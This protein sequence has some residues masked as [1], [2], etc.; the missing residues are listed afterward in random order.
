MVAM[1]GLLSAADFVFSAGGGVYV[2]GLFT[3]YTLTADGSIEGEPVSVKADQK[4]NQFNFGG[5]LFVDGTWAEFNLGMQCGLHNYKEIMVAA[6]PRIDDL[7]TS[8]TGKGS[9]IML[10]FTLLGKYPFTLNEDFALF[11]LLGLEYQVTLMETRQPDGRKRY[12][13]TD[14]L[15]GDTDV[16]GDIYELAVW[17]SLFVIIGAGMDYKIASPLFLRTELLYS[18][19]LKTPYEVDAL[20]KAKMGVNAPDPKLGGLTGGPTIKIAAGWRF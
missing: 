12:D 5:F 11:P 9:E 16:N 18:F 19:R 3:R 4:M 1:T 13:R 8:S 2:G 17:N 6:S 15:R 14:P 20:E 10:D 7:I